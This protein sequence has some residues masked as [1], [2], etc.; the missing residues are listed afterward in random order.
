MKQKERKLN[1]GYF[2]QNVNKMILCKQGMNMKIN[3]Q[4]IALSS[5]FKANWCKNVIAQMFRNIVVLSCVT[6]GMIVLIRM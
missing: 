2:W 5:I 6:R 1:V 3:S 4:R